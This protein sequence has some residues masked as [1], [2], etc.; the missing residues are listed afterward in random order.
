M[1]FSTRPDGYDSPDDGG[2][3]QEFWLEMTLQ[4]DPGIRMVVANS[5]DAPLS[6]GDWLDGIYLYRD[7]VLSKL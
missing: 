5:N 3:N 4:L 2:P 7:G 1:L 6:G